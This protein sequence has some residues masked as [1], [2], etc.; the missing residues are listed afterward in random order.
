[1]MKTIQGDL[2]SLAEAGC[3]DVIV[4]GANCCHTMDAG[5]ARQI[6]EKYPAAYEADCKTKKGSPKKMGS[7]SLAAILRADGTTFEVINLYTQLRP[8]KARNERSQANRY[9][10][11]ELGLQALKRAVHPHDRIGIP[12]IGAGL[13]GGDW[14][15]IKRIIERV[16][17]E[18]TIV[19]YAKPQNPCAEISLS[20]STSPLT[21]AHCCGHGS[22][23][24]HTYGRRSGSGSSL[25]PTYDRFLQKIQTRFRVN[26]P[27][28]TPIF[29]SSVDGDGL[30][31]AY[32]SGFD[33]SERQFHNCRACRSFF[34]HYGNLGTIQEDG[35]FRPLFWSEE[36]A[37]APYRHAMRR[38]V[39][40]FSNARV[41]GL[42]L[43]TEAVWGTPESEEEGGWHH[44]SVTPYS[45]GRFADA[46]GLTAE[47]VMA[48]K[49]QE[50]QML[51]AACDAYSHAT[52]R[53]ALDYVQGGHLY[54]AEKISDQLTWFANAHFKAWKAVGSDVPNARRDN[55]L[56]LSVAFA[57][58]NFAHVRSGVLGTLL[59]DIEA[60]KPL[61]EVAENFKTKMDPLNY[62]R[63]KAAPK[64]GT[65]AQAEK[66]VDEL[67][68]QGSFSRCFATLRD[69]EVSIWKPTL[70]SPFKTSPVVGGIFGGLAKVAYKRPEHNTSPGIKHITWVKFRDTVLPAAKQIFFFTSRGMFLPF[71]GLLTAASRM[72]P[73]LFQWDNPVSWYVYPGGSMPDQ[74]GLNFNT[75]VDVRAITRKPCHWQE[76][77]CPNQSE[78][79]IFILREC[80][81]TRNPGLCIF[82]ETL[83]ADYHGVRS[84]I[85]AH[86]KRGRALG[87]CNTSG[88]KA[89]GVIFDRSNDIWTGGRFR[90]LGRDGIVSFYELDRW[91]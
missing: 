10:A 76:G 16:L 9:R 14:G 66:L 80:H 82:P 44:F 25:D 53:H 6:R 71:V 47:E 32:L 70:G 42:F 81:D 4:H 60:D 7:L 69:I 90:V 46:S 38:V 3:F 29:V 28:G 64:A 34:K 30:F 84:V 54:R 67:Q 85:E 79:I 88:D 63:P 78:G 83:R 48:S 1:M 61:C 21:G 39:L 24:D 41:V 15:T 65:V 57:P 91:D 52:V 31:E 19:E 50:F 49:K 13:A 20:P 26:V 17:P 33:P 40:S 45:S 56:W 12:R 23:L 35:A 77:I 43:S 37:P 36:D 22:R 11:I 74:W 18:A 68:S 75:Y 89:A 59:N 87:G 73:L 58:P 5:L 72:A 2:L 86:S 62:L 8:G 51:L 55:L 27:P